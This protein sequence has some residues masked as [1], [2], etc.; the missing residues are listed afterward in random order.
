MIDGLPMLA[1]DGVLLR[2]LA[3]ADVGRLFELF[4]DPEV[5]RYWS[6]GPFTSEAEARALLAEIDRGWRQDA[7]YQWGVAIAG[8]PAVIGTATLFRIDRDHRRAEIGFAIGSAWWGRGFGTA[9]V[10]R[11]VE[12]AFGPLGVCRLEADVDPRNVASLRVLERLGFKREGLLRERYRVAGE[13][14]D[15]VILGLLRSEWP[16]P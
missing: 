7:F 2:Q 6:R 9:T 12:Y 15:S 10:T 1:G 16:R 8:S 13:V 4:S 11:L 14:Q 5:M 3:E